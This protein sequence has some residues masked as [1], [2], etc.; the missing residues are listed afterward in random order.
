MNAMTA[1]KKME[2]H[3][4]LKGAAGLALDTVIGGGASYGIGR[5]YS[6][7]S[8]KWYGKNAANLAAGIGK[9]G[10]VAAFFITGGP[11]FVSGGL[12]AIGQS[13]IDAYWLEK[14]LR[15]GREKRGVKAAIVPK[16]MQ[17]PAGAS[18]MSSIGA[19]GAAA[20]GRGLSWDA[21]EALAAGH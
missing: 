10:A 16:G 18:D 21:I 9:L 3:S 7:H 5:L 6:Q 8:D 11:N 15:H 14:G 20:P 12:N 2:I 1:L 13:G 17:L 19:L 4:P